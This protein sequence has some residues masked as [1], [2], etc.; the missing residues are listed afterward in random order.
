VLPAGLTIKPTLKAFDEAL[1]AHEAA[2]RGA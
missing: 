1:A 2:E